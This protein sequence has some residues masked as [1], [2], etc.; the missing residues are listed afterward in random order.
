MLVIGCPVQHRAWIL[1]AWAD[2]I[3]K[4]AAGVVDDIVFVLVGNKGNDPET[5]QVWK[6]WDRERSTVWVD[7][8]EPARDGSRYWHGPRFAHM[9]SLRNQL[10]DEVRRIK[11]DLFLS[12]DSDILLHPDH[13]ASMIQNLHERSWDAIGGRCYLG[14]GT[15]YPSWMRCLRPD[16]ESVTRQ[17]A[18]GCFKVDVI[19]ALKL[20]TPKAYYVDY[21]FHSKGEDIGWS[22]DARRAGCTLGWDGTVVSKHVM[23]PSLLDVFD[24]R[25]GF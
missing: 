7:V 12:I 22:I 24:P 13:L 2:R 3:E 16:G 14:S 6:D 9:A 21:R 25:S 4:A 20:M 8:E 5:Y 15:I 1:P 10:L 23:S 18:T 19:M 11:P 17:D